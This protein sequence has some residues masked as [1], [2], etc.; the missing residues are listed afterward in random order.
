M[1]TT[2]FYAFTLGMV[3]AVN[4]C[5]FPLLPA[6]LASFVVSEPGNSWSARTA[7][8]LITGACVTTGFV[9]T[10]G[11][12]G[13]LVSS[14]MTLI[15]GWIPWMMLGVGA[16][17]AVLGIGGLAG[18]HLAIRLPA[19]RFRNGSSAI[20]MA[21]FGVAYAIGSLSCTLPL[22]LA[23]VASSFTHAGILNGL[24]T[25]VAYAI[26]MGVFVIAASLI[27]AQLGA[28][29]LRT[30]RPLA[31][32]IPVVASALVTAAGFYLIYYWAIDL[33][34]PLATTPLTKTINTLQ[35]A[36]SSW[37]AASPIA[38]LAATVIIL[39]CVGALV[40]KS[41]RRVN[42]REENTT[43]A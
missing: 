21:G 22:F 40:A 42:R 33:T 2:L 1:N 32:F 15:A 23:G 24:M 28:E 35:A 8:A 6:Y 27:A 29:S 19:V 34:D 7:R 38:V 13:L 4:P 26:G 10:F 12:A 3:A 9:L 39:A 43:R 5:G 25:F 36:V 30:L 18:K 31:R 11:I 14:G 37:L 17:L 41:M 20:A 16:A